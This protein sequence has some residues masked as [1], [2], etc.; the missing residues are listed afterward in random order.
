MS[1]ATSANSIVKTFVAS[2]VIHAGH[3]VELD[4][5]GTVSENNGANT[6]V[7]VYLGDAD[8]AANDHVEVCILGPCKVWADGAGAIAPGA[9]VASDANGHA[10]VE[11][12]AG[13][14]VIGVALE[15]LAAGTAYIEILVVHH[16]L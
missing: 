5:A 7:G 13:D 3:I 10:V 4:A 15:A 6:G 16:T 12:N 11:A 2:G 14:R 8:C 9:Y 1:Q